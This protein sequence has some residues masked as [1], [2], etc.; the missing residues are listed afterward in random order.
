MNTDAIPCRYRHDFHHSDASAERSAWRVVGLTAVMMVIEILAG[1]WYGSMALLADGWHMASH[2]VAI[3]L[4][5]LAYWF[6]REHARDARYAFGTWKIEILGGFASAVLLLVVAVLMALESLDRLF[7]PVAIGFNEAIAVAVIGLA[8][9]L[10]SARMLHA[11][12]DHHAHPG[13]MHP[14]AH[15]HHT[16]HEHAHDHHGHQH[17]DLNHRAA[18]MHVL[19]DAL[20][21][22][23]AI[24]ALLCGKFFGWWWLDPLMGI[25]GGAV[26]AIWAVGLLRE[27]AKVLLD[28]EMDDPL[29]G[30]VRRA[31][32]AGDAC[33]ED[34][35]LWRVGRQ[36]YA[37]IIAVR[38]PH[39]QS[40]EHYRHRLAAYP[41][42]VHVTVEVNPPPP[43][44]A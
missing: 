19:A 34:L 2:V 41:E 15:D 4:A 11:S 6:A 27:S 23:T 33:V 16:G 22:V 9:N 20:T 10:A 25:V 18:Y 44:P 21:S 29:V 35:H 26:I 36:R 42:L 5:A 1:W 12:H 40:P 37:C 28:R 8:V 13:H 43:E 7:S 38:D 17:H 24:A 14:D 32:E 3:G 39:A 30:C 31:I